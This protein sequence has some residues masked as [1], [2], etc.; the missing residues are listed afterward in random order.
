MP[1]GLV[2]FGVEIGLLVRLARFAADQ[3]FAQTL[4]A[5]QAADMGGENAVAAQ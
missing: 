2:H 3:K 4:V 5:R 1:D